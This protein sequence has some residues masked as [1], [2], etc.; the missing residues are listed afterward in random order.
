MRHV[1]VVNPFLSEINDVLRVQLVNILTLP[2][3]FWDSS[4]LSLVTDRFMVRVLGFFPL[5]CGRI[6]HT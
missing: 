1:I 4:L 2:G 6:F 3:F 5:K